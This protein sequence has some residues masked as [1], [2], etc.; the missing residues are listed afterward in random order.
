MGPGIPVSLQDSVSP[1][2]GTLGSL[3]FSS[4]AGKEG[5][6]LCSPPPACQGPL[7]GNVTSAATQS[8]ASAHR[9][10]APPG[11]GPAATAGPPNAQPVLNVVSRP[12]PHILGTEPPGRNQTQP[13]LKLEVKKGDKLVHKNLWYRPECD[14]G[15]N[16]AKSCSGLLD[17]IL[18]FETGPSRFPQGC[19]KSRQGFTPTG[20]VPLLFLL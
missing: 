2:L 4:L 7:L 6:L 1:P 15:H 10:A 9:S 13:Y 16:G 19:I 20:P 17:H 14:K 5:P 18:C 12:T 11:L 8:A 3:L